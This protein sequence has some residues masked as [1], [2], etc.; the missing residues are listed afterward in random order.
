[1]ERLG[2]GSGGEALHRGRKAEPRSDA[3][4][5][6]KPPE[7][8]QMELQASEQSKRAALPIIPA[9]GLC[10]SRIMVLKVFKEGDRIALPSGAPQLGRGLSLME[11][12]GHVKADPGKGFLPKPRD[13]SEPS[14][15]L[16]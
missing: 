9:L 14:S 15:S 2:L 4:L 8:L 16:R 6:I 5:A 3:R 7:Q 13:I 12:A 11:A 10:S 1:M